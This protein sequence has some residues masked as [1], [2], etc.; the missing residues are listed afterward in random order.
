MIFHIGG[1]QTIALLAMAAIILPLVPL[2]N[3]LGSFAIAFFC[4][5]FPVSQGAVE[6]MN[7]TIAAILK[8]QALPKLDFSQGVPQDCKT[9]VAV[10]TLLLNER[11]VQDLVEELEVR[12]L[13]NQDPNIHFALMTDFCRIR[14]R[15]RWSAIRTRWYCWQ[16]N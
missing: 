2:Y 1:I 11:Q 14:S 6:L 9:L 7:H 3:P 4:F 13:A 16:D 15:S 8:P 5:C 10:P 12:S